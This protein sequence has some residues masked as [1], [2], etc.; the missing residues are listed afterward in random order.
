MNK[1]L[2]RGWEVE[3]STGQIINEDQM[4]WADVPKQGILRMT[5]RYDGREWNITGRRD[6]F[7]KKHA[8]VIPGI[9]DSFRIESRSI[10]YYEG[11]SKIMYTVD[12]H[13]GKMQM[14]VKNTN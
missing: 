4:E 8:S 2:F 12:E 11:N 7:Q 6:Y 10:G 9:Q 13:T 1:N 14:E 5:L 3:L